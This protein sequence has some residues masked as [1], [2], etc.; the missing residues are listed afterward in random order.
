MDL[1]AFTAALRRR[2]YLVMVVLLL[3]AGVTYLAM[4]RVGPR[5]E[6]AG[7]VLLFPPTYVTL[8]EGESVA[9]GNPYLELGGLNTARDILVRTMT[10]Q[11]TRDAIDD[12][13]PDATYDMVPDVSSAGPIVVISVS[14][15]NSLDARAA[16]NEV[17]DRVPPTLVDLQDDIGIPRRALITSRVLTV[18]SRPEI[19]RKSQ[20]RSGIVSGAGVLFLG[21]MLI[22][23]IDGLLAG[24]RGN[25]E[26][27][28]PPVAITRKEQSADKSTATDDGVARGGLTT[29]EFHRRGYRESGQRA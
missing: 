14:A 25:K 7:S 18:D 16:L 2:W 20:I 8:E 27:V 9:V 24:R 19:A 10:A 12:Q 13:F 11:S 15:D 4:D 6:L 22:G 5:H 29:K 1:R 23:V 28:P 17:L 21:L 3:S 26:A